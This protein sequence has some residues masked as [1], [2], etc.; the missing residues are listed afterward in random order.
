MAMVIRLM[1]E[2]NHDEWLP[3]QPLGL[4]MIDRMFNLL[5][6]PITRE[7]GILQL[8]RMVGRPLSRVPYQSDNHV[9]LLI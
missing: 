8:E 7:P 5:R 3:C 2:I 9:G 4:R 6:L 1:L